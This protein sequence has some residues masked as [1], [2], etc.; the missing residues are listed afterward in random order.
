MSLLN[1]QAASS[2]NGPRGQWSRSPSGKPR[3]P[4][5][6]PEDVADH[7]V[8][9]SMAQKIQALT[10]LAEGFST[11]AVQ[12]KTGIPPR[13]ANRIRATAEKRGFRPAEDPRILEV[14]VEDRK[15]LGR[16]MAITE[17]VEQKLLANIR[18]DNAGREK[19]SEVLAYEVGIS[20]TS[21]LRI[22]KKHGLT[23]VKPTRK[24]GLTAR[25]KA[26]RLRFCLNHAH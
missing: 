16:P 19:S 8:R 15:R 23:N 17:A 7:G 24:P 10:L 25:M 26:D 22:L 20:R 21:A 9:Y 13:T 5:P 6:L 1:A 3:A 2:S 14:Y 18:E 4:R 12:Q 11:A